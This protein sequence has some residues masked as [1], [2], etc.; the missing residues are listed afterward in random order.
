[1]EK[2]GIIRCWSHLANLLGLMC[3]GWA[4]RMNSFLPA[5]EMHPQP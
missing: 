5:C 4:S 2:L 3:A 1:M